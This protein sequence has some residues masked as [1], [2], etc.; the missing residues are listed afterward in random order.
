M[1]SKPISCTRA[2]A[3]AAPSRLRVMSFQSC[4]LVA[5]FWLAALLVLAALA[6]AAHAL[7]ATVYGQGSGLPNLSVR[8]FALDPEGYVWMGTE[9]GVFRFDGHRFESL[10]LSSPGL[11][12][13]TYVSTMLATPLALYVATR[14]GLHRFDWQTRRKQVLRDAEGAELRGVFAIQSMGAGHPKPILAGMGSGQLLQ[15]ADQVDAVPAP[16]GPDDAEMLDIDHFKHIND[17]YGHEAGDIVLQPFAHVLSKHADR[18]SG[19]AAGQMLA[20]RYGGEEFTCLISGTQTP[21]VEASAVALL[22]EIANHQ[23]AIDSEISVRLT[24]SLG[25]AEGKGGESLQ[26]LIRRADAA[27][28]RVKSAGRAHW[29]MG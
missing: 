12:L 6:P 7:A 26:S 18:Y 11:P 20:A 13:D 27:L 5:R 24:A 10:D 14:T 3:V 22:E 23:F 2:A 25:C 21:L 1:L 29:L 15:F 19:S 17:C 9:D 16:A 28:Y 8:A 4:P